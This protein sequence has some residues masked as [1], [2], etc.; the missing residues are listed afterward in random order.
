MHRD[1]AVIVNIIIR[2]RFEQL[3]HAPVVHITV[4]ADHVPH[5]QRSQAR[6]VIQLQVEAVNAHAVAAHS[7]HWPFNHH[8]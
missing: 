1:E 6:V 8:R 5:L 7:L 4:H 2:P 3:T